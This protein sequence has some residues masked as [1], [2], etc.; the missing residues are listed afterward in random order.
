M[1]QVQVW[2]LYRR[3]NIKLVKMSHALYDIL[4]GNHSIIT[5]MHS[6]NEALFNSKNGFYNK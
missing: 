5:L 2:A 3:K 1:K 6:T 4:P